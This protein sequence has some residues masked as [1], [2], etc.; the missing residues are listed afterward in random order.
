[1]YSDM[2]SKLARCR[3]NEGSE[4]EAGA[5]LTD[6]ELTKR[7]E[8]INKGRADYYEFYTGLKWG[9]RENYDLCINTSRYTDLKVLA[10]AVARMYSC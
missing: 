8:H 9:A 2:A 1:M 7:I 3:Q 4:Y 5:S 10:E 6:K